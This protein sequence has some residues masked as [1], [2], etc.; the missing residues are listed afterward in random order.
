M[1]GPTLSAL[2]A[3]PSSAGTKAAGD[4]CEDLRAA[5]ARVVAVVDGGQ[6]TIYRVL[7]QTASIRHAR[8]LLNRQGV[9][10]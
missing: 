5:L 9:R 7:Q 6:S 10:A 1:N 4:E 8:S 2:P 3:P